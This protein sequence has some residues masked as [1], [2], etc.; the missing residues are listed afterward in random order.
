MAKRIVNLGNGM[1]DM[2]T[3]KEINME[4]KRGR[5]LNLDSTVY[6]YDSAVFVGG[7]DPKCDHDYDEK[8]INESSSFGRWK[9]TRCGG[10]LTVEIWK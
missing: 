7:N 9:C 4:Q 2:P 8:P 10:I 1:K 3:K 6:C 5:K